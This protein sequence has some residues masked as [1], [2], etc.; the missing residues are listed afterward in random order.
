LTA[1]DLLLARLL[2]EHRTLTT[3]QITALLF[4]HPGTAP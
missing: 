2:S 4:T 3:S 1:R